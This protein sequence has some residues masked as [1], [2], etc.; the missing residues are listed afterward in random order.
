MEK[1]F[2]TR[3]IR[4]FF[5]KLETRGTFIFCEERSDDHENNEK[6]PVMRKGEGGRTGRNLM[7]YIASQ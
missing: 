3:R 5:R 4:D 6:G 1:E 2:S 7:S